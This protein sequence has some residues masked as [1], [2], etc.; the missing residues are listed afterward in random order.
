MQSKRASCTMN[1]LSHVVPYCGKGCPFPRDGGPLKG[2]NLW[3][4]EEKKKK[5]NK[6]ALQL[7]NC[8]GEQKLGSPRGV[9][10]IFCQ[11][12][13]REGGK[14][15]GFSPLNQLTPACWRPHRSF[16][17]TGQQI[18]TDH[19]LWSAPGA[20]MQGPRMLYSI[21]G[22]NKLHCKL[23]HVK[24]TQCQSNPRKAQGPNRS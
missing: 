16:T 22:E 21:T 3:V 18:S 10:Q 13:N 12:W 8:A 5:K 17:G 24:M 4:Q 11:R 2:Y 9:S 23:F 19:A 14:G 6:F 7:Q 1:T 15:N 20:E